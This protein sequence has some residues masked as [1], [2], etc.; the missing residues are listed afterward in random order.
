MD[1]ESIALTTRPRLPLEKTTV[2]DSSAKLQ[3]LA[4]K[5]LHILVLFHQTAKRRQTP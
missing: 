1:F 3:S 2:R 5:L 4:D